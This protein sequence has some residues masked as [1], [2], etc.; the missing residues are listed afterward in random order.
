[1][2]P[3]LDQAM[4][5]AGD[6]HSV[7]DG[8]GSDSARMVLVLESNIVSDGA[9][10][11]APEAECRVPGMSAA[12]GRGGDDVLRQHVLR[13]D[14]GALDTSGADQRVHGSRSSPVQ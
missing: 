4:L 13:A 12:G 10:V 14:D 9:G 1:M 2:L 8:T 7:G 6:G 5:T 3:L 11:P